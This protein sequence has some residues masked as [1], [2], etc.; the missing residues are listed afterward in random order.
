MG[1]NSVSVEKVTLSRFCP[2][3]RLVSGAG[4]IKL[5]KDGN[6]LLHEMVRDCSSRSKTSWFSIVHS[7]CRKILFIFKVGGNY[8][9]YLS[10]EGAQKKLVSNSS[11][12]VK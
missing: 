10:T 11:G 9:R 1:I 2:L 4:D 6:V 5:T 12:V 8:I 3:T 7:V